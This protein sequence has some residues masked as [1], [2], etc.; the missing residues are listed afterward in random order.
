MM[1][2][3]HYQNH[4]AELEIPSEQISLNL[5]WKRPFDIVFSLVILILVS[6]IM[7]VIAV[8]IKLFDEGPIFF[9]QERIGFRGK[10]FKIIKFRTM[11]VDAE[12]RLQQYLEKNPKAREE[13]EKTSTLKDDPRITKIG[14][15]L[16]RSGLDELPQF[17]SVL[18][19]DMSVVGPRPLSEEDFKK[20]YRNREEIYMMV[21]PG[22]TGYWQVEGIGQ[23]DNI[24]KRIATDT[25]YVQ[26]IS[27]WV[28]IKIILKTILIV[29]RGKNH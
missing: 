5:W 16:R 1:A 17:F 4:I 3:Y 28:D 23:R 18:K 13:W 8:I 29:L 9:C 21:K 27:L 12:Q 24:P 26:N 19:G 15:F 25:W 6:P 14:R 22:I 10:K 11:Y 20:F 7:L 2:K